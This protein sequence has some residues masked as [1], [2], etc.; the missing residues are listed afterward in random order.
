MAELMGAVSS[1]QH[2]ERV[3]EG[4]GGAA[5]T[6]LEGTS[7]PGYGAGMLDHRI[8]AETRRLHALE[9]FADPA[10]RAAL[11]NL[12]IQPGWRCLELGGGTGSVAR[13]LAARCAPG[14]TVVT[15]L[16]TSLLPRDV[17]NLSVLVHDVTRDGF[18]DDSFD[19]VHARLLLEHLPRPE[20]V[21]ADMV[22]WTVPGG[23]VCVEGI[24]LLVPPGGA[25]NAFH[26]CMDGVRAVAEGSMRANI[27]WATA[28]PYFLGQAGL[29]EV[30]VSCTPGL[31]G[32][33]GRA[34]RFLQLTVELLGPALTEQG[35]VHPD[36]LTA[37]TALLNDGRY[38]DLACLSV[39][40]WGRK[41]PATPLPAG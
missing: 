25:R 15:D 40:A 27:R 8:P 16:D 21:L 28:L 20:E 9:E 39:S 38:T 36:D 14:E 17:P 22:R 1:G 2:D 41:P 13:W 33:S 5:V 32:Q 6:S 37:C 4:R 24:R 35:L 10:S 3:A 31:V 23:W 30:D 26:R 34:T 29:R 19:L 11:A 7:E 12:G 18:P